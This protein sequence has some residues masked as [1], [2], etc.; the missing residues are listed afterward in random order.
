MRSVEIY[1]RWL[2]YFRRQDHQIAESASLIS[3]DPS[4]LFTIAG[5]VPF[6]PY[7]TGTAQAPYPRVA[8]VQKCIRTND[9]DNVGLTTRHGTFFQMC[10]N[11][12]FGDYFKKE[13]LHFAWELLTT[14]PAQGGFGLSGDKLWFSLWNEDA[15]AYQILNR[16][17]GVDERH[18]VRLTRSE[19]FWSTGQPG[20]A[21]PCVEIHYDRGPA[22]GPEAVGGTVDPGGDRYLEI[23]NLVFDEYMRGAGEGSNYELLG[24]LDKHAVDT[25][26]GLERIAYLLQGKENMYETDQVYPVIAATTELTGKQ[27]GAD[28]AADVQMRIIADHIRSALMLIADGVRPGNDGRGYVLRR[29]IRRAVRSV[30]LLGVDAP[31]LPVLLPVSKDAMKEIYPQVEQNF[32]TISNIAYGEE[33]SFRRTLVAGTQIFDVA[34]AKAKQKSGELSGKDA[35]ELH[36]TYGFP[37]DLTLEMAQ[38]QGVKVDEKGFRKFMQEQKD[39]ARADAQAKKTGHIDASVFHAFQAKNGGDTEFLGYRESGAEGKVIG[40]LADGKPVPAAEAPAEIEVVLDRTPFYAEQ[41]GQLA[42]HGTI[43]IAGGG[44]LEVDDVQ[45]PIKGLFLHRGHLVEGAIALDDTVYAQIDTDRRLQIAQAHTATHMLHKVLHE[46]LGDQATQAGSENSPSRLRFDFRHG[47]KISP[48]M[49]T[50]IEQRINERLQENLPVGA[51]VMDIDAAKQ[52]GAMALFGEKYGKK[53]RVVSIDDAWSREFCAGTHV[54]QTGELGLVSIL[55][56]S[57]IGSGVRRVEAL[58]GAGAYAEGAKE[59]ALLSQLSTLVQVQPAALPEHINALLERLKQA[60]KEITALRQA[61]LTATY[62]EILEKGRQIK[63][64]QLYAHNF[65]KLANADELR[66]AATELRNR[67]GE[68]P[69]VVALFGIVKDRPLLVVALTPAAQKAGVKAGALVALAAKVLGGGGG[70]KPDL[71]QGGGIDVQKISAAAKAIR[72]FL[73]N[74]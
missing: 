16:E 17:I 73:E 49:L 41:G 71:A 58:V 67:L 20:P 13:A 50:E 22:Y 3:P 37:I 10:G 60:E 45:M 34:V 51:Q 31:A 63:N 38:E 35:F 62:G 32:S 48:S 56:E 39:R 9:I 61:Q 29:L 24:K 23:W 25:G 2:D 70:G 21:G 40:I 15:E 7:I 69:A 72:D 64:L 14:D 46:F 27:Y 66:T 30:R 52:L 47:A 36:D 59:R 43:R 19:I 28:P 53:V 54:A 55:G 57:S 33:E 18:L 74:Q 12:S 4:I 68:K 26:A 65:Q 42:D 1:Q 8:S 11:F 6:I 44:L 5:M